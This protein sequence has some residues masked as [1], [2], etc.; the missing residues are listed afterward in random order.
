VKKRLVGAIRE[1]YELGPIW[2]IVTP[3]VAVSGRV[4]S[5]KPDVVSV[6]PV[7]ADCGR[8]PKPPAEAARS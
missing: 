4:G 2:R 5:G 6:V 7:N 3:S 1:I 8:T